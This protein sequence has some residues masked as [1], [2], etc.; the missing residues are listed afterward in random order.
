MALVGVVIGALLFSAQLSWEE[1]ISSLQ[2]R[3]ISLRPVAEKICVTAVL[4]FW[5]RSQQC[6][7]AMKSFR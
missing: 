3:R 5:V 7:I 2:A 1:R 4:K 6:S